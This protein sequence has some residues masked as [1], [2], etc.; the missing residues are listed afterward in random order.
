MDAW[1]FVGT[2]GSGDGGCQLTW[3]VE[4]VT[5]PATSPARTHAGRWLLGLTLVC[6]CM[7]TAPSYAQERPTL[8]QRMTGRKPAAESAPIPGPAAEVA[9]FSAPAE[10]EPTPKESLSFRERIFGKKKELPEASP[11]LVLRD[12]ELQ[13]EQR[14]DGVY[15]QLEA[16]K[17][18]YQQEKFSD[19]FKVF[20]SIA[21]G[22]KNPAV[23]V[24][25]ALFYKAECEYHEG[26]YRD[27]KTNYI[28]LLHD[29]RQTGRYQAQAAQRLFD[30]ANYWL[31]DTRREIQ[32]S[33]DERWFVRPANYVSFSRNKPFLD[34]EGHALQALDEVRLN[35]IS[36]PL[37][38]KSLFFIAT[39]KFHRKDYNNADYYYS[40]LYENFPN[41]PLAPKAVKQAI[42]CKQLVV[43]GA[44]YDNRSIEEA[45]KLVDTAARAF[46]EVNKGDEQFLERQLV[47]ISQQ[48]AERDYQVAE[49][50][51]RTGHP[52][53]A[54]FYY[55]LVRRRYPNTKLAEKAVA[56][57]TEIRSNAQERHEEEVARPDP[58]ARDG[59]PGR[60]RLPDAINPVS[61]I[62]RSER[63]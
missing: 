61:W 63:P 46:P 37:G 35:D 28:K 21:K 14:K 24:E 57:M 7:P 49:F 25:E 54:Y 11:G 16:G 19:A 50:Y 40:Q 53:S 2:C 48:Q 6:A 55:E 60:L 41:S 44:V 8:W 38:E 27:A 18:L 32:Q 52:G 15:G 36:G 1:A 43:H 42:L 34:V 56:Q 51:R 33:E 22:K 58:A 10:K 39:V 3:G 45:R 17:Q 5:T 29:F 12:G 23:V 31:D 30:I 26:N 13:T 20:S 62:K 9:S 59:E 47:A 4:V